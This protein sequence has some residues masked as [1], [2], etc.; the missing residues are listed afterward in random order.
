M[1][2][3][4]EAPAHFPLDPWGGFAVMCGYVGFALAGA[5]MLS[6]RDA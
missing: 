6:V 2:R 1:P 5:L 3:G 4:R